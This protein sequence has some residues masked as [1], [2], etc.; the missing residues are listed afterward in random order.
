MATL[1][2]LHA[3]MGDYLSHLNA[4]DQ[5]QQYQLRVA[6]RLWAQ[7]GYKFLGDFLR[8]TRE[9][10]GAEMGPVD[11]ANQTEAARQ[12]INHWVDEQTAGKIENLIPSGVLEPRTKLVLTNAIYFK[13]NW[14][15]PFKKESTRDEDF[16][17]ASTRKTR[18]PMM[19]M[20]E[21][22]GFARH[23]GLR[24]LQMPYEGGQLSMVFVLS[25]KVEGLVRA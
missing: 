6:N 23:D 19:Q 3:G 14:Q 11:F 24:V 7:Q 2:D 16:Q 13:G 18:V 22:F 20:T 9:R 15:T 1:L 17:L 8:I 5:S 4:I 21:Q 25:D 10:Y 12:A